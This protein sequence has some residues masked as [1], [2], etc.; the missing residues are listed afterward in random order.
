MHHFKALYAGDQNFLEDPEKHLVASHM[1]SVRKVLVIVGIEHEDSDGT[2][3]CY[4]EN[5]NHLCSERQQ[6][7]V[8]QH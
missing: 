8:W 3:Q 6:N 5:E 2:F 7:H 4:T 1:P